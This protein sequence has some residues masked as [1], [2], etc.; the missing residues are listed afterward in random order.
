MVETNSERLFAAWTT[1]AVPV[2]APSWSSLGAAPVV[3]TAVP[4]APVAATDECRRLRERIARTE[5][6]A[7]TGRLREAS[8]LRRILADERRGERIGCR[9]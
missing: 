4:A 9:R 2:A 7:A 5:A 8:A 6:D 1:S 3:A